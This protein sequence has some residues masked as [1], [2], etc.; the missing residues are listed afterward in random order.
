MQQSRGNLLTFD[1]YLSYHL[2]VMPFQARTV[3]KVLAT[4]FAALWWW[5]VVASASAV[6]LVLLAGWNVGVQI[7]SNGEPNFVAGSSARMVLP[8]AFELDDVAAGV[9]SRDGVRSGAVEQ[10]SGS[11]R[12]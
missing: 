11:L 9:S 12:L 4:L 2:V 8:V 6:A 10:A 7:G 1:K 3:A 5:I